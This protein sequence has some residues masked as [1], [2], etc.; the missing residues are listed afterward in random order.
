MR[1]DARDLKILMEL[2]AE[3]RITNQRLADRVSLSPSA[4]LERVRRL[5]AGGLIR[6]YRAVVALDKVLR[7]S[8]VFVEVTLKR[9]ESGDFKRFERKILDTPE[10]VE[11]H[12]IGGGIDYLLKVVAT[13]IAHYQDIMEELLGADIGIGTYFTYVVTKPIKQAG[14]YPLDRLVD[15]SREVVE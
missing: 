6:G 10:V 8:T 1:L 4:C 12:A 13:D 11:C 7:G 15:R 14:V 5:E 2:Q 3:G 9:H